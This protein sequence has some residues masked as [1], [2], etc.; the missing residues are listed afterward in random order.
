MP[1]TNDGGGATYAGY[2]GVVEH[3]G[4]IASTRPGGLSELDPEKNLDGTLIEGD[5][6]DHP[7]ADKSEEELHREGAVADPTGVAPIEREEEPE[8][9]PD[10]AKREEERGNVSEEEEPDRSEEKAPARDVKA[11]P[12]TRAPLSPARSNRGNKN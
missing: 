11:T 12:A 2:T 10:A 9:E 6:P 4:G 3:A 8:H 5:H 1:K 7:D